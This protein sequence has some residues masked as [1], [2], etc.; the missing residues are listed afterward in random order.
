LEGRLAASAGDHPRGGPGDKLQVQP[1]RELAVAYVDPGR[2]TRSWL[3]LPEASWDHW[4]KFWAH[5][6]SGE[7]EAS[8]SGGSLGFNPKVVAF[9]LTRAL[10]GVTPYAY[11]PAP[12]TAWLDRLFAMAD[13]ERRVHVRDLQRLVRSQRSS[14][15]LLQRATAEVVRRYP[16]SY[17]AARDATCLA[18]LVRT[19]G[20]A[21]N[22]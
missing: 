11:H 10:I 4:L 12:L 8:F 20:A 2:A 18:A 14:R 5:D 17:R 3:V 16:A 1:V 13:L 22:R 7:A 6:A 21:R 15:D 9:A 19:L